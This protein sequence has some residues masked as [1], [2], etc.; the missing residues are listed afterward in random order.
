MYVHKSLIFTRKLRCFHINGFPDIETTSLPPLRGILEPPGNVGHRQVIDLFSN[1]GSQVQAPPPPPHPPKNRKYENG[2]CRN[3]NRM[4]PTKTAQPLIRHS[5]SVQY[6]WSNTKEP[7][8]GQTFLRNVCR[9]NV[10]RPIAYSTKSRVLSSILAPSKPK[11]YQNLFSAKTNLTMS[12]MSR[13]CL[14]THHKSYDTMYLM[15]S[16]G[17]FSFSFCNW[18]RLRL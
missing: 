4:L 18:L 8:N 12:N 1:Q 10:V 15:E 7:R 17:D 3:Q 14:I 11:K 16:D 2:F 5:A 13:K 9:C 6:H